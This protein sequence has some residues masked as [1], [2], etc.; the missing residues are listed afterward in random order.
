MKSALNFGRKLIAATLGGLMVASI[1]AISAA[2]TF[3]LGGLVKMAFDFMM[4]TF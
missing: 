3:Y 4:S 2:V 1:L